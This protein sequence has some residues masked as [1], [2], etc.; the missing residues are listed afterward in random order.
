MVT[1]IEALG[2]EPA[3]V[4]V[5]VETVDNPPVL[6]LNGP[7]HAGRNH[8]ILYN[9]GSPAIMVSVSLLTSLLCEK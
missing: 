3:V 7:S 6:D 9:E 2:S 8:S 4:T 1:D 5:F